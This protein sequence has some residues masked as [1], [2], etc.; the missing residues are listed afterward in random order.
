MWFFI[1]V[2]FFNFLDRGIV[3]GAS[4]E[5]DHFILN[6]KELKHTGG[7]VCGCGYECVWVGVSACDCK[8]RRPRSRPPGGCVCGCV[9]VCVWVW[10]GVSHNTSSAQNGVPNLE[11]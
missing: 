8:T 5:F 1:I 9:C 7:C 2:N 6:S 3:P 10:V 11:S 4:S